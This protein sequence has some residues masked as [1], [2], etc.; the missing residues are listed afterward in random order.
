MADAD[1]DAIVLQE[2]GESADVCLTVVV[3][4]EYFGLDYLCGTYQ[5]VGCHSV[6]LVA[7]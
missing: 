2:G 4:E 5:L 7:G 6:G 1:V 3:R